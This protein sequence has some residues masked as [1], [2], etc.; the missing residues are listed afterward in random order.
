MRMNYIRSNSYDVNNWNTKHEK[1]NISSS[2]SNYNTNVNISDST[3]KIYPCNHGL[4][5]S[6]DKL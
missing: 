1:K 4:Q 3:R 2:K 6:Q 5:V